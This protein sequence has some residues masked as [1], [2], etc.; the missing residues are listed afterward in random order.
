MQRDAAGETYNGDTNM[1]YNDRAFLE[2]NLEKLVAEKGVSV[3]GELTNQMSKHHIF[4]S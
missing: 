3:I 1:S 2:R 4:S